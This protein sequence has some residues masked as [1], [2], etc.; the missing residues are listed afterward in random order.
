MNKKYV[1]PELEE[2]ELFL[3]GSFLAHRTLENGEQQ[4]GVEGGDTETG[5]DN[6]D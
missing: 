3:E 4:E 1:K 5:G 2:M 6:W